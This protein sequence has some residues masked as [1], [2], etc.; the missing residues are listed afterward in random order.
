MKMKISMMMMM[1][2][3]II[4]EDKYDDDIL[5]SGLFKVAQ[6]SYSATSPLLSNK[7]LYPYFMRT[8]ASDINQAA[9]MADLAE[10]MEWNY[11]AIIY[12]D[13]NYGTPGMEHLSKLL[14]TKNVCIA[15]TSSLN[16][17]SPNDV[18]VTIVTNLLKDKKISVR[19]ASAIIICIIIVWIR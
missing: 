16:V 9:V 4:N 5:S 15:L 11:V 8:V 19:K 2:L 3:M 14:E 12:T 1:T 7:K 18:V 6:V 17:D 13:G 10:D